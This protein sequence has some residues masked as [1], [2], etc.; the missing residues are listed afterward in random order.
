[1][2]PGNMMVKATLAP[3]A[4][5]V[6]LL[7]LFIILSTQLFFS[8]PMVY[9]L[10]LGLCFSVVTGLVILFSLSQF[11]VWAVIA[12]M[13][14]GLIAPLALERIAGTRL[15]IAFL[16]MPAL[17][18]FWLFRRIREGAARAKDPVVSR[19]LGLWLA[20]IVLAFLLGN[21]PWFPAPHAP[22]TAQLAGL[23][24]FLYSGCLL[25]M[26]ADTISTQKKLQKIVNTF[27]L[28]AALRMALVL[29]PPS[30]F[31]PLSVVHALFPSAPLGST[32]W[33]WLMA[34]TFGQLIANRELTLST[35]LGLTMLLCGAVYCTFFTGRDW[36]SGWLPGFIACYVALTISRPR[37]TFV[38]TLLLTL[39]LLFFAAGIWDRV[40][41]QDQQ[42]SLSTRLDAGRVLLKLFLANPVVGFG[43]ANYYHY[44]PL[45]PIRGWYVHFSSHNTYVDLLLQCGV[46]GLL[47]FI[48]LLGAGF[49]TAW[50]LCARS[51]TGFL[52]GFA[53][54]ATGGIVGTAVAGLLGD[55]IVPFVYNVGIAGFR[56]SIFFWI[57]FGCVLSVRRLVNSIQSPDATELSPTAEN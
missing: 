10:T 48:W 57:F 27:F 56:T 28:L 21:L 30:S 46:L 34:L 51:G 29:V 37:L 38:L 2:V 23:A 50:E 11:P 33:T 53:I 13:S 1:M 18:T 49:K 9:E 47:T 52:R 41:T 44:T 36:A 6:L 24:M 25:L 14:S 4:S 54:G 15:N 22:L 8:S 39:I 45:L 20:S 42:Y 3:T 32:F 35:R 17:V 5:V 7:G 16:L 40:Y 55:W 12:L 31:L 19:P 26:T 43:P